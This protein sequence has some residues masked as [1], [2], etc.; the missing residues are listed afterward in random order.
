MNVLD[1]VKLVRQDRKS[2]VNFRGVFPCDKLPKNISRGCEH[3]LI[4]NLDKAS[5]EGSHWVAIYISPF[6]KAV[7]FDSYGFKPLRREITTF[8]EINSIGIQ[9]NEVSLQHPLSDACGLYCI[10]FIERLCRG[11]SLVRM[12]SIFRPGDFL[13]NDTKI[14][15]IFKTRDLFNRGPL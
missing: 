11:D 10:Y 13:Y 14:Y 12:R 8:L 3:S 1:I 6:Q 5:Q 9:Y 4:V 7:Y 2:R 15:S